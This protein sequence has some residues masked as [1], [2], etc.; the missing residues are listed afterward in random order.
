MSEL[1]KE[2]VCVNDQKSMAEF[3]EKL[4]NDYSTNKDEWVNADLKSFLYAMSAWVEDMD[5][6]YRNTG[7]PYDE[8]NISWKNFADVLMASKI[9]E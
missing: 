3:I 4:A 5:N 6:Y 2:L 8:K 9:Y 1:F 7:Q